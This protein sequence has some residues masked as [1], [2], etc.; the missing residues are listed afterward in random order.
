MF[1]FRKYLTVNGQDFG[2]ISKVEKTVR[3]NLFAKSSRYVEAQNKLGNGYTSVL[4]K[5]AVMVSLS[6]HVA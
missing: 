5:F 2:K 6:W 4:N 1:S 3:Y